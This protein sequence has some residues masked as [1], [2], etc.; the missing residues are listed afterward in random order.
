MDGDDS[1][2]EREPGVPRRPAEGGRDPWVSSALDV[3]LRDVLALGS[4]GAERVDWAVLVPDRSG[5]CPDCGEPDGPRHLRRC[6]AHPR[7][8]SAWWLAFAVFVVPLPLT[9]IFGPGILFYFTPLMLLGW[10]LRAR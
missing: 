2:A 3:D 9:P 8:T 10:Y 7:P 5:L 6:M 4:E 1:R